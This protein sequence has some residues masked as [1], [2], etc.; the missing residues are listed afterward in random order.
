M[1]SEKEGIKPDLI[2][3]H[4]GLFKIP[5][6]AQQILADALDTPVS[7]TETAA[8]GGAYGMALLAAYMVKGGENTLPAWLDKAV[9]SSVKTKTL[10]PEK[11]GVEGY[12]RYMKNYEKGL[13]AVKEIKE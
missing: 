1:L 5:G 12:K 9:F 6:A 10:I 7:V 3:A 4:G 13:E 2:S 8:E 11:K